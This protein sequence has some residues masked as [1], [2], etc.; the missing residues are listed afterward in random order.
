MCPPETEAA[1]F[2]PSTRVPPPVSVQR[3]DLSPPAAEPPTPSAAQT[4]T[5]TQKLRMTF[6]DTDMPHITA[7]HT[8]EPREPLTGASLPGGAGPA[9]AQTEDPTD[10]RTAGAM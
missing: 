1:L 5:N 7:A 4:H 9:G 6:T 2:C 8:P 3:T 10:W